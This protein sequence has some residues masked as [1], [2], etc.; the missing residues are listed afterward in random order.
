MGQFARLL[1]D[2][3]WDVTVL[4][5]NHG[6][7][8]GFDRA[9]AA[10]IHERTTVIEAWSPSSA[11]S[12]RGKPVAKTGI[13]G[14]ARRALRTA[15]MSVMFP[16]REVL[17]VPTAI[18]AGRRALATTPHDAILATHGPASALLVGR[19][20]AREFR[21]P[22]VLDF[23]DLWATLPMPIFTTPVHRAAARRLEHAMVKHASR[24]IAVAP[25]MAE[26]LAEAHDYPIE[27]TVSITNGFDPAD[28]MRVRDTRTAGQPF[29]LVYS[30]SVHVHYDLAPLWQAIRE[31]AVAGTIHPETFRIEFVGNLSMN[32]VKAGGVEPF[33]ETSPFVPHDHVFE[34]LG[35]ADALLVVETPGY[36]ARYGY[37]AKVFDYVLTGKPVVA[38]VE[39]G[40][41]TAR[42]LEA[43]RVGHLAEPGDVEGIKRAIASVL[44]Y[45][46][47]PARDIDHD[48]MPLRDFNRVHLVEK[49]ARL[50]D[51]V[52]TTEPKGRW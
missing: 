11:V 46:G 2:F 31:L 16:D 25:R 21:L 34:T 37:A 24:L 18:A 32:D 3:G 48:A 20:L 43:A 36:Y 52:V 5:A 38:L 19:A 39:A 26:A 45:G 13:K 50:L 35:R 1:P 12:T 23:R 33:V 10:A 30:G 29:R 28:V 42:L 51:D 4:T 47:K 49:L 40:G 17:W 9:T 41:N 14:L 7:A 22:L 8:A 44:P 27:R 6:S 15:V